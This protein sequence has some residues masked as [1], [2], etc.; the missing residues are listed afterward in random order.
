MGAALRPWWENCAS[1]PDEEILAID[2]LEGSIAPLDDRTARIRRLITSLELCH[3]KAERHVEVIIEAIGSGSTSKG[4]GR[5]PL[6]QRH[7]VEKV[8]E[9]CVTVLSAWRAGCPAEAPNLDVGDISAS[10]LLGFIGDRSL[11]KEWQVQRIV[12]KVRSF[13]EPSFRYVEMVEYPERYREHSD[14]RDLTMEAIIH[15][16]IDGQEAEITLASA[17]DHL[18]P[19]HWD[20]S[21]N[22]V[23]VLRAIGGGLFPEKPFAACGRNIK[24]TPI[25]DRMKI[26]SDTLRA[27]CEEGD[28]PKDVDSDIFRLLEART[29]IKHWLAASLEKTIR[30][31]LGF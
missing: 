18:E 1:E 3:H 9:H 31:Q 28:L 27:F 23:L 4:P 5:R 22:L 20:F 10:Q 11:L 16:T 29:P 19:C 21:G 17:I 2:A 7:P 25:R 30:S 15:D 24:L 26:V 12:D 6:G 13:L 14:F 8:W